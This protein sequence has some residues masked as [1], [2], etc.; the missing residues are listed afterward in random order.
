MAFRNLVIESQAYISVRSNRLIIRTDREHSVPV[1]DISATE[2]QYESIEILLGNLTE[3]DDSFQT[4]QLS[5][6]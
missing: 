4:E 6:F 5:F 2:K 3:A 1:E